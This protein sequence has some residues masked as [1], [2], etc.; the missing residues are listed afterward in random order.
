MKQMIYGGK[1]KQEVIAD[2]E[3][4]GFKWCVLSYGTHPCC[5]ITLP[6]G[7]KFYGKNVDEFNNIEC[8][9]GITFCGFNEKKL[10][11]FWDAKDFIIGW[12]YAHVGDQFSMLYSDAKEWTTEELVSEIKDVIKQ[13]TS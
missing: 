13:L 7:H 9:G 6:E 8:H 10:F 2:G 5:Y 4:D 12:D 11:E 3:N 1:I